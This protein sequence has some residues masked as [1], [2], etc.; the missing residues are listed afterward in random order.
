MDLTPNVIY[1]CNKTSQVDGQ[2]VQPLPG[3]ANCS[4]TSVSKNVKKR[5]FIFVI[6]FLFFEEIVPQGVFQQLLK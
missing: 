3:L 6:E 1:R 4:S 2:P 5:V